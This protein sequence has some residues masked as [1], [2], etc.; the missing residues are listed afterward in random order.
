MLFGLTCF[1]TDFSWVEFYLQTGRETGTVT[2]VSSKYFMNRFALC[3]VLFSA[4]VSVGPAAAQSELELRAI[5]NRM[6]R[7]ERD[8]LD[9]QRQT[10]Q[11]GQPAGTA[12]DAGGQAIGSTDLLVRLDELEANIRH[13]TGQVEELSFQVEQTNQRLNLMS[14]DVEFRF[15]ELGQEGTGRPAGQALATTRGP[16]S[17]EARD[18]GTRGGAAQSVASSASSATSSS[19]LG[20]TVPSNLGTVPQSALGAPGDE[21]KADTATSGQLA[22]LANVAPDDAYENAINL[23][24]RGDFAGAET[25]FSQFLTVHPSHGL[26]GNAQYWLGETYYVRGSYKDAADA[27]LKGYTTYAG[28]PKAPDSLLKLGITLAALG[29]KDS[30]CATLGELGRR[31]PSAPQAV[32][33]R[34]KLEQSKAGCR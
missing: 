7:I 9:L 33:Q 6:E 31:F 1:V 10:Y 3:A 15:Q 26:A 29:Q 20:S 5:G 8:L 4:V 18:G 17:R 22:S 12:S 11:T 2:L 27:F 25:A 21:G 28:S 24:K 14:S 19:A 23:L 34:A 16:A 13:L 30:A 32:I